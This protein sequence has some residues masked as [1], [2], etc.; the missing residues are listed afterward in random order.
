MAATS[1]SAP[2][3]SPWT[4]IVAASMGI[5]LPST[6]TTRR[7]RAMIETRSATRPGSSITGPGSRRETSVPE[8][9]YEPAL[10]GGEHPD[11]ALAALR[12]A[13]LPDLEPC[14]TKRAFP[15]IRAPGSTSRSRK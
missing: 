2:G 8:A 6:A 3:V 15:V 13:A 1:A 7:S 9:V 4:Q 12:G 11:D 14:A 10:A 5:T